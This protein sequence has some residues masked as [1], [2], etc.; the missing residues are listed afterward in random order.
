MYCYSGHCLCRTMQ[1]ISRHVWN[2]LYDATVFGTP[3]HENTVT[4]SMALHLNR[5]HPRENRVHIFDTKAE[6]ANG[7]DFIWLFFDSNMSHYLPVAVQAKRIY[8]NGVYAAFK[9]HQ[10]SKIERYARVVGAM[11]LFLTYNHFPVVQGLWKDWQHQRRKWRIPR[12]DYQRDLGLIYFHAQCVRNVVSGRLSAQDVSGFGR[13]MWT[14]FCTCVPAADGRALFNIQ[15]KLIASLDDD[16]G[17]VD[18]TREAS[19][20]VHSWMSGEEVEEEQ[21]FKEF[22]SH[23]ATGDDG[24]SPSFLLGTTLQGS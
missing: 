19:E 7:S 11:P 10:V 12:L 16:D 21:I 9:G 24:F 17:F 1:G 5:H 8:P 22:K 18:H 20:L 13:P 14:A 4:Q 23:D 2:E 15:E 3:Y 6:S